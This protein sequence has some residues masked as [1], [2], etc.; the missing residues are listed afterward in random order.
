MID[1][2]TP[3]ARHL[4]LLLVGALLTTLVANLDTLGLPPVLAPFV[5]ALASA[6]LLWLT[7][8]TSQY[9]VRRQDDE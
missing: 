8:L 4:I 3:Q 5:G 1:R 7:P 6:A 9:G 2:L